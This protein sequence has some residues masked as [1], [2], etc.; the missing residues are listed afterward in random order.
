MSL[1]SPKPAANPTAV[2]KLDKTNTMPS[3][4][5]HHTAGFKRLKMTQGF[6][7]GT[8]EAMFSFMCQKLIQKYYRFILL[9]FIPFIPCLGN[10][11]T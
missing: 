9:L 2:A 3:P 10:V 11:E 8:S 5:N 6:W 1:Q 4:R 7:L